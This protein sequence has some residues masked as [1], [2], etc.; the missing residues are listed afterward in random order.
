MATAAPPRCSFLETCIRCCPVVLV[1]LQS[2]ELP[3][4]T[5]GEWWRHHSL[6]RHKGGP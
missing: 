6:R 4:T 5:V 1:Q 3:A 2:M